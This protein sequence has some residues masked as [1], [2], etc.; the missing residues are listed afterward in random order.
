M[1]ARLGRSTGEWGFPH[2]KI[3]LG[4]EGHKYFIPSLIPQGLDLCLFK[5][6]I[7]MLAHLPG[8]S[9]ARRPQLVRC[10]SLRQDLQGRRQQA[11]LQAI[12][13]LGL[14]QMALGGIGIAYI[15]ISPCPLSILFVHGVLIRSL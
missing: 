13:K 7:V 14:E 2:C 5:L 6:A 9:V 11:Y 12:E 15:I 10:V 8:F 4:E 3:C 1:L